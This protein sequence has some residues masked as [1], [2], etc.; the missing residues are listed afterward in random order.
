MC[1]FQSLFKTVGSM[2]TISFKYLRN[3]KRYWIEQSCFPMKSAAWW[4]LYDRV[5]EDGSVK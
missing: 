4:N 5:N 1:S 3:F 2:D